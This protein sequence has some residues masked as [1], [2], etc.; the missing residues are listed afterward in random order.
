M[1]EAKT[2]TLSMGAVSKITGIPADTIRTWE[3]RYDVVQPARD[4]SSR[5]LYGQADVT[6][7]TAIATLSKAGERVADLAAL[8]SAELDERVQMHTGTQ[9]QS[10]TL[11]RVALV[12][13]TGA[14]ALSGVVSGEGTRVEVVATASAIG[15]LPE[16]LTIDVLVVDLGGL[17]EDAVAEL[18]K[19]LERLKT[20]RAVVTYHFAPREL[21]TRLQQAGAFL[22]RGSAPGNTLRRAVFDA[23]LRTQADVV[24]LPSVP[25]VPDVLFD[26]VQLEQLLNIEPDL[27]CEC[28]NH[29][30]GLAIA[31][32]EFELYSQR[33]ESQNTADAALHTDLAR[34]TGKMRAELEQLIVRVCAQDG[35][36]LFG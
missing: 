21:Q 4:A 12:H 5:R 28:P 32:R 20:T 14:P 11:V 29:L 31:M 33:C 34:A 27:L 1:S 22:V 16:G 9:R 30:A 15:Q 36:E 18:R 3:R 35:I 7:L 25:D 10:P 13:P 23:V 17:G 19:H 6:R 24:N 8:S 2:H 26:R